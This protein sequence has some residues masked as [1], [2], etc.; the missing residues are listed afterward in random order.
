VNAGPPTPPVVSFPIPVSSYGGSS[1]Q[2]FLSL[3]ISG[4]HYELSVSVAFVDNPHFSQLLFLHTQ[5]QTMD[6]CLLG[7]PSQLF[8]LLLCELYEGKSISKLQIDIE[9]KQI[10][11]LI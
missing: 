6:L 8:T 2:F 7:F 9:H 5:D 10:R 11:V 1:F 4:L 3:G